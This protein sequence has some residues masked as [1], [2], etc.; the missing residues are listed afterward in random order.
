MKSEKIPVLI[1]DDEPLARRTVRRLLSADPAIEIIGECGDGK[2]AHRTITEKR[3]A[4]VYLDIRMPGWSGI[5][6]LSSIPAAD[7]PATIFATA[8]D[9]FAVKAFDLHAVD[10]LLKPFS[11]ER[12]RVSLQRAKAQL[13]SHNLPELNARIDGLLRHFA[14][15]PAPTAAATPAAAGAA[16][17]TASR[18]PEA[19]NTFMLRAGHERHLLN[20]RDIRWVEGQSDYV[21]IHLARGATIFVRK[22]LAS[23]EEQL[24]GDFLRIHKSTIVNLANV[25]RIRPGQSGDWL[26]ELDDGTQVRA[27]RN[28]RLRLRDRLV[29]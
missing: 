2:T 21:R 8:F 24:P 14:A 20:P 29:S 22:T 18:A 10:Y 27:S 19:T 17:S 28:Y 9:E 4:I 25:A 26:V 5:T 15:Q 1:V 16:E 13:T 12:F 7:R 11:D 6:M 3:P 23:L